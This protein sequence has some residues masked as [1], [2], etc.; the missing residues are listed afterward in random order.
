MEQRKASCDPVATLPPTVPSFSGPPDVMATWEGICL[1]VFG[2]PDRIL[3]GL[4]TLKKQLLHSVLFV[5][6]TPWEGIPSCSCYAGAGCYLRLFR[7]PDRFR[8]RGRGR[9][10]SAPAPGHAGGAAPA[11]APEERLAG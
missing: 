5:F 10:S 9:R 1:G 6:G 11:A 4:R 8:E 3:S 7:G 2:C